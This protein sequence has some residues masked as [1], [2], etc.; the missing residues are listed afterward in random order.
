MLLVALC[1]RLGLP[2]HDQPAITSLVAEVPRAF[3]ALLIPH[4]SLDG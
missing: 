2:A 3:G 4:P 1:L